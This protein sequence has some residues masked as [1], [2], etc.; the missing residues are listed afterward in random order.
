[1]RELLDEAQKGAYAV[2]RKYIGIFKG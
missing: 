2:A 1:M